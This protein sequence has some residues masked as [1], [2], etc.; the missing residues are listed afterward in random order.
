MTWAA[1]RTGG[2]GVTDGGDADTGGG[3]PPFIPSEDMGTGCR[4]ADG[5]VGD[6]RG[7]DVAKGSAL[8]ID[9]EAKGGLCRNLISTSEVLMAGDGASGDGARAG[10]GPAGSNGVAI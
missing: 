2:A 4:A 5:G 6:G 10:A 9:A 3:G 8:V 7:A 1:A